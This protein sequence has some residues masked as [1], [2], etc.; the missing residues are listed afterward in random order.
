M[1]VMPDGADEILFHCPHCNVLIPSKFGSCPY[2]HSLILVDLRVVFEVTDRRAAHFAI[3]G[4]LSVPGQPHDYQLLNDR[5]TAAPGPLVT[6]VP[7][8]VALACARVLNESKITSEISSRPQ[9]APTPP[10]VAPSRVSRT[11]LLAR[12]VARRPA[13]AIAGVVVILTAALIAGTRST[14]TSPGSSPATPVSAP[15]L[16]RI[17]DRSLVELRCG[18]LLATGVVVA[19]DLVVANSRAACPEIGI[20]E[21]KT[22]DGRTLQGTVFR[23][24]ESLEYSLLRV[25]GLGEHDWQTVDAT[26]LHS[27]DRVFFVDDRGGGFRST[28]VSEPE[29]SVMGVACLQFETG[30]GTVRPGSPLVD[31]FGRLAGFALALADGADRG[32]ALPVNYLLQDAD[33]LPFGRAAAIDSG[34][35]AHRVVRA[36]DEDRR[37]IAA[38][39]AELHRPALVDARLA[40][41]GSLVAVVM[42]QSSSMPNPV[43]YSFTVSR[44]A[45]VIGSS[46]G[47]ASDWLRSPESPYVNR[48]WRV[49]GWLAR[50]GLLDATYATRLRLGIS[51]LSQ[52]SPVGGAT[53]ILEGAAPHADRVLISG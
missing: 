52:P 4:L 10:P 37:R 25:G 28:V 5:M 17:A 6:S 42:L 14:S 15:E 19:E 40:R 30:G 2:C 16:A 39:S 23:Q 7:R 45:A 33:G 47:V 43:E 44:N 27:G 11:K 18:H 24:N 31:G 1:K 32:L 3:R 12:F 22:A 29:R 46:A 53:L 48:S 41:D 20:L 8:S 9:A 35:W 49:P 51:G 13:A 36:A 34:A 38:G 50:H 21:V 26:R